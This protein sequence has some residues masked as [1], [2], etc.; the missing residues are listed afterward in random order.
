MKKRPDGTDVARYKGHTTWGSKRWAWELLRRHPD[1][2]DECRKLPKAD[3]GPPS[4]RDFRRLERLRAQLAQKFGLKRFKDYRESY[5]K[6]TGRPRFVSIEVSHWVNRDGDPGQREVKA[7][8][9]KGQLLVRFDLR[10][11]LSSKRALA[12]QL[13]RAERVASREQKKLLLS[14][15]KTRVGHFNRDRDNFARHIQVLDLRAAGRSWPEIA[16]IVMADKAAAMDREQIKDRL[17]PLLREAKA[18]VHQYREVAAMG[19]R[20]AQDSAVEMD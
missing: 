1:F 15:G 10:Q 16:Q 9:L 20:P 4:E 13:E 2:I 7:S 5:G 12:E 8:L 6:G 3:K 18:V 14:Q 19:K 17:V 11:T